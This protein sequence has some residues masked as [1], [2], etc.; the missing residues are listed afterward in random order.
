MRSIDCPPRGQTSVQRAYAIVHA[1]VSSISLLL[2]MCVYLPLNR[3]VFGLCETHTNTHNCSLPVVPKRNATTASC[4][5]CERDVNAL[6][7]P[8]TPALWVW[9][10]KGKSW[11]ARR[12]LPHR[13]VSRFSLRISLS[14]SLSARTGECTESFRSL[15]ATLAAHYIC[16][17]RHY[18]GNG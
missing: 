7:P 3:T 12:G 14:L 1:A 5:L 18:S 17:A 15:A 13:A 10:A 2:R 4:L 6:T 8:P 11:R 9:V 16:N